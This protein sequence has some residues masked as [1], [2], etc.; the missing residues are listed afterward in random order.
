M[1]RRE[2]ITLLG[3]AAVAW[4]L[5]AKGQSTQKVWLGWLGEGA[6]A[7]AASGFFGAL[8]ELGYTEGQNLT[9]EYRFAN[10]RFERLPALAAELVGLKVDVIVATSTQALI[11]LQQA[12]STIPIV[13]VWPGDPVGVGLVKSL[14]H[15]GANITGLSLMMPDIGGKRLQLL[16]EIVPTMRR[17]AIFGNSK[18]AAA[19]ADMRATEAAAKL[20]GLQAHMV[21]VDSSERLENGLDEMVNERPDGVVVVLDNLTI[22]NRERIAKVALRSRLASIVPGR[23]YVESGC[24]AGFGPNLDAIARRAAVYVDKIL[25][26]AKPADLPVEQPTKFELVIN[27]KTARAIGLAIPPTLLATAD[28]VIE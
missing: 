24:L 14:A 6:S 28:E 20:M 5:A 9:V 13:M 11:A 4:P 12:T 16:K 25:K 19:A 2:F 23:D 18:N 22:T 21:G 17:V 7:G 15:P 3:S 1:R 10:T 26:G 27:L 8:Q